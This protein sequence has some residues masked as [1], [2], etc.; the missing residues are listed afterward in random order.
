[1]TKG[2]RF[3]IALAL[4]GLFAPGA[5]AQEEPKAPARPA[6]PMMEMLRKHDQ[7]LDELVAK[8]NAAKGEAKVDAIAEVL[9]ELVAQRKETRQQ[10]GAA[11]GMRGPRAPRPEAKPAE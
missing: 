9:N 10:M 7:K 3:A 11:R 2:R 6:N 4:M 1:M 5:K 8:M